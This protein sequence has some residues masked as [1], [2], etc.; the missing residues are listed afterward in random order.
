MEYE[1]KLPDVGEGLVE[2]E[3]A[4]WLV[5]VGDEVEVDQAVVEVETAK[6]LVEI[7]TPVAGTV[8]KLGG[9]EGQVLQ[10]GQTLLTVAVAAGQPLPSPGGGAH[11]A[12]V[13]EPPAT[14][15]A[16]ESGPAPTPLEA[17][18]A[19]TAPGLTSAPAAADPA[20]PSRRGRALASPSTRK[21]ARALGIDLDSVTGTGP[22]GRITR[23]DVEALAGQGSPDPIAAPAAEAP[24]RPQINRGTRTDS[25][26]DSE[27]DEVVALRG[28]RRTIAEAMMRSW[29]EIPHINEF[30]EIDA[31]GLVAAR[32]TLAAAYDDESAGHRLTFLPLLVAACTHALRRHREFNASVDMAAE[33]IVYKHS[34]DIGIAT[35]TD[36][37]LVVPV[38]RAAHRMS[39]FEISDRIAEVTELTRARRARPEHLTGGS[40][41]ITNFG[42]Y[43][44][45]LG[46]PVINPPQSAIV[47]FGRIQDRPAVVAGEIV[48][49]TTLPIVVAADHRVIDGSDLGAFVDDLER[50]L[51]D[52]VLLLGDGR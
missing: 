20:A 17:G 39:L 34:I 42:S 24:V 28:T 26:R 43:G 27:E 37:G 25:E 51:T 35:A 30:R 15:V 2:A 1:F 29:R 12:T 32:K 16:P 3:V 48:V 38:L 11:A 36:E 13:E 10:V 31:A 21:A 23:A 5:A 14:P 40:F 4:R 49:R 44:T 9:E 47:G 7:P 18:P 52:P 19:R 6:A 45:W 22:G 50:C 33:Q 41:T 8:L 46:N